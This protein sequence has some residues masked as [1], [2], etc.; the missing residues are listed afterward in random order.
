MSEANISPGSRDSIFRGVALLL[1]AGFFPITIALAQ[2][3]TTPPGNHPLWRSMGGYPGTSGPVHCTAA[4]AAGN[5]YVGGSFFIAGSARS[6]SVAK[7]DG[8]KWTSISPPMSAGGTVHALAIDSQGNLYAGGSF[9]D[10]GGTPA[11]RI[12]KWDGSYWHALGTGLG[13]NGTFASQ[14]VKAIAIGAD[15]QVYAGGFFAEAGSTTVNHIAR[16]DGSQWH[17]LGQGVM[18]SSPSVNALAFDTAGNLYATGRFQWANGTGT[19][20]NNIA[21]WNGSTWSGLGT[22]LTGPLAPNLGNALE[23]DSG[24]NLIA[25]GSFRFAGGVQ[26]NNIGRWNGSAW[27]A[28]GTAGSAAGF[29]ALSTGVLALGLTAGGEVLAA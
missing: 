25:A 12:A 23:I 22:G 27:S 24:G 21:R 6:H 29:E 28:F 5:L 8:V 13:F 18:D 1:L 15:G 4:D 14:A 19:T 20:V 3:D 26:V 11:L 16:W 10:I 9:R 7:W 17:A 2:E